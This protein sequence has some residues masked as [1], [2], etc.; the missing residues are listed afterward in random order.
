MFTNAGAAG[1]TSKPPRRH[2]ISITSSIEPL[3]NFT[4]RISRNDPVLPVLTRQEL[5]DSNA[6]SRADV[7]LSSSSRTHL[8]INPTVSLFES[9]PQRDGRLPTCDFAN[10]GVIAVAAAYTHRSFQI[11][12]TL[13][14]YIGY[15]F[16]DID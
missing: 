10:F 5:C 4:P 3:K 12:T 6:R 1:T 11:V 7:A 15:V 2:M 9:L 14:F 8:S 13:Q 16:N